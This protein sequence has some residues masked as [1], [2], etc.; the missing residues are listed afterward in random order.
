MILMRWEK[1]NIYEKGQPTS[2]K[3]DRAFVTIMSC[4]C[5]LWWQHREV[6]SCSSFSLPWKV[7]RNMERHH[8]LR[9]ELWK[10]S[11]VE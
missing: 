4:L 1:K 8:R 5:D 10:E 11:I 7:L 2:Y 9:V 3:F 6:S